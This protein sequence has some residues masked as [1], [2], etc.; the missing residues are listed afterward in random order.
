MSRSS[1]ATATS[2]KFWLGAIVTALTELVVKLA[3]EPGSVLSTVAASGGELAVRFTAYA[4]LLTLSLLMLSG[5]SWAR[6]ALLAIFGGLGT[7]SLVFE[8]IGWLIDGGSASAFLA[9]ADLSMWIIIV[10]RLVHIICVWAAIVFMFL[11][12]ARGHLKDTQN[13]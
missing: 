12:G 3:I 9:A 6:W 4:V 11:P 2:F 8:P 13:S 10:S 1:S 7:Y 5:R